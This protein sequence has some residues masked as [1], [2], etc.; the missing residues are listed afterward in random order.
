L[1]T[2]PALSAER[3]ATPV[4]SGRSCVNE[5]QV[6]HDQCRVATKGSRT[7]DEARQRCL[8]IC[9]QKKK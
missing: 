6:Q 3:I 8:E 2:A 4:N 5:C 1:A 7:C 9:L